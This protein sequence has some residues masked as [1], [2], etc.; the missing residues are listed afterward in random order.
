MTAQ[1]SLCSDDQH[2]N[3]LSAAS[4]LVDGCG[5]DEPDIVGRGRLERVDHGLYRMAVIPVTEL[6]QYMEMVLRTG[7]R[8]VLSHATALDLHCLCDVN[9]AAIDITVPAT[10]RTRRQLSAVLR[11]H[12]R[13]LRPD[14]Q[15]LHE[16]IPIVTPYRAI[17]D[18]IEA[19][20]GPHLIRQAIVTATETGAVTVTERED[21]VGIG[22]LVRDYEHTRS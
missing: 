1:P 19:G 13:E 15:T 18:G 9:P 6:D 2:E 20:I 11:V 10:F 12:R 3:R 16:G 21:L 8:G 14:E 4:T 5:V 17:R 22:A 7:R